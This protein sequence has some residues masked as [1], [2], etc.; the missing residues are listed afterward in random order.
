M[1]KAIRQAV[2]SA[3]DLGRG[4]WVVKALDGRERS[5]HEK[6]KLHRTYGAIVSTLGVEDLPE[7]FYFDL[8]MLRWPGESFDD[9]A[10][11]YLGLVMEGYAP[12]EIHAFTHQDRFAHPSMLRKAEVG[13]ARWLDDAKIEHWGNPQD[14]DNL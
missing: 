11:R 6:I 5:L 4:M 9:C 3:M 1:M 13:D 7:T 8:G 10:L 14:G 2:R 12:D